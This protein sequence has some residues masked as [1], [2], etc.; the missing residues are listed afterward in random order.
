MFF[1]FLFRSRILFSRL[2][3]EKALI[4]Q[5]ELKM[6]SD[7]S[8]CSFYISTVCVS[9]VF[10][11]YYMFRAIHF[12]F[13][14][15]CIAYICLYVERWLNAID[16]KCFFKWVSVVSFALIYPHLF[17]ASKSIRLSYFCH[18]KCM[19]YTLLTG[20]GNLCIIIVHHCYHQ[21]H[22]Y[23]N[24]RW[25]KVGFGVIGIIKFKRSELFTYSGKITYD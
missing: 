9:T 4:E 19:D 16:G 3:K 11:Y 17:S 8:R 10:H 12:R 6:F 20:Q 21:H 7:Y 13:V 24:D 22:H 25:H 2:L 15:L 18:W 23:V 5:F 1:F 14:C